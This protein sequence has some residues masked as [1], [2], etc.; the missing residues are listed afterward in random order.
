[1]VDTHFDE[2]FLTFYFKNQYTNTVTDRWLNFEKY[3]FYLIY[4]IHFITQQL[5]LFT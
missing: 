4:Y 3:G 5:P 2:A 1:M